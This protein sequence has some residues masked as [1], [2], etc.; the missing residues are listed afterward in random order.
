LKQELDL[1]VTSLN[2]YLK[3]LLKA[4]F[5]SKGKNQLYVLG[6]KLMHL[7]NSVKEF[8]GKG[9]I[10]AAVAALP[11]EVFPELATFG[12]NPVTPL[13]AIPL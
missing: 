11:E 13:L 10:T 2:R 1:N 12:H 3:V 6:A 4:H 5:V 7:S 9:P 8:G